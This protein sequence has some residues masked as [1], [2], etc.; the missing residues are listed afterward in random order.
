MVWREIM[1]NQKYKLIAIFGQAGS[2][3]DFAVKELL[4]TAF[5]QENLSRVVSYTTRPMRKGEQAGV[6]YHFLPTAA[7]FFSKDLIEH[8]EFRNWFYGSAIDN[9]SLDKINVGVYDIRRIQQILKHE[10]IICYPIYIKATD[11][12][13]LIRQLEREQ[14]PDCDEIVRRYIADKKDFIPVA[15]NTTGFDF[16]TIENNDSKIALLNDLITY[17]KHTVL[18]DKD[19]IT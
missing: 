1:S 9:L 3:K 12:N 13:R 18:G 8:S 4:Q 16:A 15:F 6:N 14:N 11:K 17:I 10:N 19:I 2:G 5:G 7:Q